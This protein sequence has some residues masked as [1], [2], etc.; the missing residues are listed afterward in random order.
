MMDKLKIILRRNVSKLYHAIS[1]G[2]KRK[3]FIRFLELVNPRPGGTVLDLGGGRGSFFYDNLDLVQK[4]NLRVVV[5][6]I[7]AQDLL[8]AKSRGFETFTLND[9]GLG[10]L[11]D[12]QFETV[13]C[14]SVIE[15]VNLPKDQVWDYRAD[16]FYAKAFAVQRV[17][18][19]DIERV[20]RKYFV[21]TPCVHFPLES[22]SWLPAFYAY[23]KS[24]AMH[25]A[26]LEKIS[27]YWIKSTSPDFNLLNEK[28]MRELFPHAD[29]VVSN[30]VLGFPKELIAYR[31]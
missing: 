1:R 28:Q 14:N 23:P 19:A 20:A 9:G 5:A 11:E 7:S 24:R 26:R 27:R 3:R 16:D 13:F 8:V 31:G 10:A 12:G 4:R 21:Q 17:F 2:W 22:H 30:R 29:E 18:A 6:D 15:H 25:V